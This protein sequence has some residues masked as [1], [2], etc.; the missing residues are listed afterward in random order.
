MQCIVPNLTGQ[1]PQGDTPTLAEVFSDTAP[2]AAAVGFV[3]SRLAGRTGAILW[4]QDRVSALE[5]G[6]PYLP[7]LGGGQQIL[8]VHASRP[9]D[10][11]WTMEEGL[12]CKSLAAVIGEIWGDPPA[13][14]FTA[15]KRLAMRAEAGGVP[16][17]LIRRSAV[18]NLSAARARWRI[19]SHPSAPHPDDP[20]AP[21]SPRWQVEL[22][23]SRDTRTGNW[24]VTDER[25][26][27]RAAHHL[28]LPPA[29]RDGA[30]AE[31]EDPH[32]RRAAG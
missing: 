14:S 1:L 31:G 11:L 30:V 8:R 20:K 32:Q 2:D 25:I 6:R 27:D 7:G 13:L 26:S 19:T 28:D 3:L 29:F 17:W 21:G 4:V 12:R 24:M 18:P 9:T 23:R 5:A 15:T 16:C 22:F 10:M